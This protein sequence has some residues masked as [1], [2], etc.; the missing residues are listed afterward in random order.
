MFQNKYLEQIKRNKLFNDLNISD[1]KLSVNQKDFT[2]YREGDIIFKSGD[3]SD[4]IY[5]LSEGKVKIKIS[6][7][8]GSPQLIVKSRNDFFGEKEIIEKTK[9]K[10][11]AVAETD[12]IIVKFTKEDTE[13]F[14]K[15][16][17]KFQINLHQFVAPIDEEEEVGAWPESELE[18]DK[19]ALKSTTIKF[20]ENESHENN[21]N[22]YYSDDLIEEKETDENEITPVKLEQLEDD[23]SAIEPEEPETH[24]NVK[25]S[26]IPN[27]DSSKT[28]DDIKVTNDEDD[29]TKENLVEE[30][31]NDELNTDNPFNNDLL[32]DDEDNVT[33]DFDKVNEPPA[34]EVTDESFTKDIIAEDDDIKIDDKINDSSA[35]DEIVMDDLEYESPEDNDENEIKFA[36]PDAFSEINSP[37]EIIDPIQS[38]HD[39]PEEKS[40]IESSEPETEEHHEESVKQ[41]NET[42]IDELKSED[43]KVKEFEHP[44]LDSDNLTNLVHAIQQISAST[45]LDETL[46]S[47]VKTV[48]SLIPCEICKLFLFDRE[49]LELVLRA[50]NLDYIPEQRAKLGIG[51]A[52]ISGRDKETF[53]LDNPENDPRFDFSVDS[54]GDVE[55]KNFLCFPIQSEENN[56]NGVIELFNRSEISFSK[57]DEEMLRL[58]SKSII[59]AIN[60]SEQVENLLMM[61]RNSLLSKTTNFLIQDIKKPILTTKYYAEHIATKDVST[62]IKQILEILA[63]QSNSIVTLLQTTLDYSEGKSKA[64]LQNTKLSDALNSILGLLAEYVESRNVKLFRKYEADEVVSVDIGELYQAF[65]Q[66]VKN[67]CDAMP[68]GGNIYIVSKMENDKI[69][70]QIKDS[71][72]GVPDSIKEYI[73]DPFMSHGKKNNLGIGLSIAQS[74]IHQ[75]NGE[76]SVE[77]NLGE[78]TVFSV[79]LPIINKE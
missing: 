27:Q 55:L 59:N 41:F 45:R 35:D 44:E 50:N 67:A 47:I 51:I 56:L 53:I 46:S 62:D 1:L 4:F 79:S 29:Y 52:G 71:G 49:K 12:C 76:I 57:N 31:T 17:K 37:N 16:D 36:E 2:T 20:S 19:A 13:A 43:L 23:N 77:S 72:L 5:L 78:G 28:Q 73:F 54:V 74:I 68:E 42:E 75:H 33:W 8:P 18:P 61:E 10:S 7:I 25:N 11:S 15:K 69:S 39:I 32:V 64:K 65:Y 38:E 14:S 40:E 9:R 22:D 30:E 63:A 66:I 24:D 60:N 6:E 26:E 48:T 58:I 34:E 21:Y 3:N 70:I